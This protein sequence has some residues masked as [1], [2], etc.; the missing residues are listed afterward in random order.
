MIVALAKASANVSASVATPP[1]MVS[2][3]SAVLAT[4]I[5]L[6]AVPCSATVSEFASP[7]LKVA[8]PPVVISFRAA[9]PLPSLL[10]IVVG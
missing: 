8:F 5:T 6:S 9:S 2:T 1:L 3:L 4:L 7:T 10:S